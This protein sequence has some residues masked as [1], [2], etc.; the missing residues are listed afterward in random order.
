MYRLTTTITI[1]GLGLSSQFAHADA[2]QYVR[3]ANVH[4]ADL[5]LTRSEAAAVLYQ[6]LAGAAKTVCTSLEGRDLASQMRFK[7]CVETAV[8]LAIAK[9]DRPLLT[10]YYKTRTNGRHTAVQIAKNQN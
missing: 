6:R 10:T 9:V 5:D 2:P 7:G 3:F 8:G 4:F 1:I